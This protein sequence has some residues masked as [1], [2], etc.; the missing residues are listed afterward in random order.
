MLTLNKVPE[1]F[2]TE[3]IENFPSLITLPYLKP[4]QL[5][6]DSLYRQLFINFYKS[7]VKLFQTKVIKGSDF[8]SVY[9]VQNLKTIC[10]EPDGTLLK[11]IG[12]KTM[13]Q[14]CIMCNNT[15]NLIYGDIEIFYIK[16][17][18]P[19][20]FNYIYSLYDVCILGEFKYKGRETLKFPEHLGKKYVNS[21]AENVYEI[22]TNAK[23]VI[24]FDY[25]NVSNGL[26]TN[27]F[28]EN[29]NKHYN[30]DNEKDF[31]YLRRVVPQLKEFVDILI[32][33]HIHK[34]LL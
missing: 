3:S 12:I 6:C 32:N 22:L 18:V 13:I 23:D 29:G 25:T 20:I 4:A 24:E 30:D 1:N 11:S 7:N 14:F 28:Y 19:K 9:A 21:K 26:V 8:E 17:V 10:S 34:K 15:G 5:C 33:L 2:I 31:E 27:I 16:P